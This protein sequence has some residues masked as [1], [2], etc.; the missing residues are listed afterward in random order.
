[1]KHF[2]ILLLI[3][4]N[5]LY[6]GSTTWEKIPSP[7]GGEVLTFHVDHNRVYAGT[8]NGIYKSEDKGL[9]WSNVSP[10][11]Y[12]KRIQS[13]ATYG[14]S[15]VFALTNFE[16][17][18]SMDQGKTWNVNGEDFPGQYFQKIAVDT[19][20]NI[21]LG[22]RVNFFRSTNVGHT[23]SLI[24]DSLHGYTNADCMTVNNSGLVF[25]TSGYNMFQSNNFGITWKT[26]QFPFQFT[27]FNKIIIKDPA[28]IYALSPYNNNLGLY[29]TADTGT[30]WKKLSDSTW[31]WDYTYNDF[32]VDKNNVISLATNKGLYYSTNSGA[33]WT[34]SH[35]NQYT[36]VPNRLALVDST[37]MLLG[38]WVDGIFRKE[39]YLDQLKP[40]N[41]NFDNIPLVSVVV[42][43]LGAIYVA[44]SNA[45]LY[46]STDDGSTWIQ[47]KNGISGYI[48]VI[49]TFPKTRQR[50]NI[51]V[52]TSEGLYRSSDGGNNW[53]NINL[54]FSYTSVSMV[55]VHADSV[56]L[57]FTYS[58]L[59]ISSDNGV[60]WSINNNNRFNTIYATGYN[61]ETKYYYAG[62]N[63]G[64]WRTTNP[65]G[66]WSLPNNNLT[67]GDVGKLALSSKGKIFASY[68]YMGLYRSND[69][70]SS[71]Y[72]LTTGLP[73]S[74]SI[75]DI[76]IDSKEQ[77]F[78]GIRY[79][80]VYAS[81]DIGDIWWSANEGLNFRDVFALAFDNKN[82]M[83]AA[84]YGNGLYRTLEPTMN[85]NVQPELTPTV[86]ALEQ[87]YPNPFNPSTVINYQLPVTNY[88]SLK[89]YDAI[90]REVAT[91]VNEVQEAGYYSAPFD[92]SKISSGI[93]FFKLQAG[94][95]VQT[96]KM[97]LTK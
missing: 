15:M 54:P 31:K 87:N 48:N 8:N 27:I 57:V 53:D 26:V 10:D 14:D 80:G 20:G 86:F 56:F 23:W 28:H 6:A 5:I 42:D 25:L 33:V 1:M 51:F 17:F 79:K 58:G 85:I 88:V 74:P 94:S 81:T 91:L 47:L 55:D 30:T 61:P 44:Q 37:A 70:A 65:A 90:G 75:S 64:V 49:R 97:M 40:S 3:A 95:F 36:G 69:N 62:T 50:G 76:I 93:Y 83:I 59:F 67:Y 72:K 78:V 68:N 12:N 96:K 45:G 7:S 66:T 84:T 82:R 19:H 43:S 11:L 9:T 29:I 39:N 63:Q 16:F 13:I 77:V 34:L 73:T 24:K 32:I 4:L 22:C 92:A 60:T 41:K 71:F 46:K 21:F 38:M 35:S 89:V 52:G 2:F 18:S